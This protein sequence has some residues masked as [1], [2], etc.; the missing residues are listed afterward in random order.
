MSSNPGEG[1]EGKR[2]GEPGLRD[3]GLMTVQD[4]LR[5][6]NACDTFNPSDAKLRT[7]IDT[8]PVIAWCAL[9]NGSNEFKNQRWHDYTGMPRE[10]GRGWAWQAAIHPE[11]LNR[12]DEKWRADVAA[13]Q[14]GE[15]E[16]RLRRSDGEYRWFLCRCEPLRGEAGD[17]VNWYGINIDIDDLKHAEQKLRESEE[18]FHRMTDLIPQAT[19]VL[20]PDGAVLYANRVALEQTGLTLDEVKAKIF[21]WAAFHP[22]D[23]ETLRAKAAAGLASGQRFELDLCEIR[24]LDGERQW[25]LVRTR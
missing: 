21:F 2:I 18:E 10:T 25:R 7:N 14:A 15:I 24:R 12:L 3:K 19:T 16:S 13:G 4:S 8:I 9:A 6:E 1:Q 11:D 5:L 20:S 23:L 17:V 22:E